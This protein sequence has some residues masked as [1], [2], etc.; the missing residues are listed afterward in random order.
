MSTVVIVVLAV[1]YFVFL[2]TLGVSTI[3]KGHWIMFL[4]GIPLPIFWLFGA[5]M[6]PKAGAGSRVAR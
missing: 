4:I 1:S 6:A 5:L 3:R 2:F